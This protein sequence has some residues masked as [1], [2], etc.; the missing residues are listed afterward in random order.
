[1]QHFT[2][3][4][5]ERKLETMKKTARTWVW[6]AC[7]G[8]LLPLLS[9]SATISNDTPVDTADVWVPLVLHWSRGD[10]SDATL[11]ATLSALSVKPNPKTI[12]LL[13]G[14]A[15]ASTNG[16]DG[17]HYQKLLAYLVTGD[18]AAGS[19]GSGHPVA[20]PQPASDAGGPPALPP[21]PA[22][23]TSTPSMPVPPIEP[24]ADQTPAAATVQKPKSGAAVAAT[25]PPNT[26]A[27][28]TVTQPP[29]GNGAKNLTPPPAGPLASK[30]WIL[31]FSGG[32]EFLNPYQ[33]VV[34]SGSA[35]GTLTNAGHST[36]AYLQLD[37]I[38]RWV[39]A[40]DSDGKASPEIPDNR[41]FGGLV[42]PFVTAPD[43]QVTMGFILG[44]GSTSSNKTY[45]AQ[46]LAGSDFYL[47]LGA[48]VPLWR[49]S[50]YK[51]DNDFPAQVSLGGSL[52]VTTEGAFEKVH[53]NEF[54]G[55]L[56]DVGINGY[57]A[58]TNAGFMEV[59][60]GFGHLDFPSMTGTASQVNL[61]GNRI[62]I[63]KEQWA[64]EMGANVFF[65][66]GKIYLNLEANAYFTDRSPDQWNIKVGATIPF[67]TLGSTFGFLGSSK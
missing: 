62:P 66:V 25:T 57:D 12:Q 46:S 60:L 41:F 42:N 5:W 32:A 26:N 13:A 1:M 20:A 2:T 61:D 36:V 30:N 53:A 6:L 52:G 54:V 28:G 63:F 21:P 38:R 14:M 24:P 51:L 44:G 56:L 67:E 64:P 8:V 17:A 55:G 23:D 49:N 29:A 27:D 11:Y 34:P 39:L 10:I 33:I 7:L 9:Q 45:S 37:L 59:K 48:G 43:V 50:W 40:P 16:I 15:M 4:G 18:T 3:F 65:P 47:D 58:G 31:A 22:V 19:G 35:T